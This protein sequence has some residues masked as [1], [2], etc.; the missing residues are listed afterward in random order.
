MFSHRRCRQR[1]A[2]AIATAAIAYEE[3]LDAMWDFQQH[4]PMCSAAQAALGEVL[5]SYTPEGS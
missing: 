5:Q 2:Q 4:Y 1:E 3:F